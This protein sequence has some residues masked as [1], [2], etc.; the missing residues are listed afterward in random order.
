MKNEEAKKKK[1]KEGSRETEHPT[2]TKN[3]FYTIPIREQF[4]FAL[5]KTS[6]DY[7]V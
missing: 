5:L 1:K 7:A 3:T 2:N 4:Y 6:A